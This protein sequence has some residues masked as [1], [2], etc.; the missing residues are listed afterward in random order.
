MLLEGGAE[1]SYI[2]GTVAVVLPRSKGCTR[3]G[4]KLGVLNSHK[5]VSQVSQPAE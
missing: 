5:L 3:E 4:M 1:A 2:I